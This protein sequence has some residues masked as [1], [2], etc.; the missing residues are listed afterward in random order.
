MVKNQIQYSNGCYDNHQLKLADRLNL[1]CIPPPPAGLAGCLFSGKDRRA[2]ITIALHVRPPPAGIAGCRFSGG[3]CRPGIGYNC[4][5]SPTAPGGV[6][7]VSLL[8]GGRRPGNFV[9][10]LPAPGRVRWVSLVGG[11]PLTG[12]WFPFRCVTYRPRQG[13]LSVS[14][15]GKVD[16]WALV[17][18]SLC[19]LPPPSAGLAGCP[20]WGEDRPGISYN[21]VACPTA[22]GRARWVSLWGERRRPGIG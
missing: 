3:G 2:G 5:V 20:L 19:V 8:K 15:G 22:P 17:T 21:F 4:A 6:R 12:H 14:S 10:C 9:A 18:I 11:R 1:W 16:D 13:S 7:W